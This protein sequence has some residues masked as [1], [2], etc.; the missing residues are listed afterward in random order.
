[1]F[2]E[3]CGTKIEDGAEFCQN[4]GNR[5][6]TSSNV[7]TSIN[8]PE[9]IENENI[10]Y[11]ED[12][13]RKKV[14]AVASLPYFDIMIDKKYLYVIEM[15]KYNNSTWGFILGLIILNII[16][17]FIGSA[18]GGSSDAKKRK[19]YRA[20]WI[21][22]EH[23][24]ISHDYIHN[25]FLKIPL[26][27]LRKSMIINKNKLILTY[28]DKEIVLGRIRPSFTLNKKTVEFER[29]NNYINSYVL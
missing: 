4:C 15:P 2:C 26:G 17:A 19:K 11:S 5:V 28:N 27:D 9:K 16:G 8:T 21:N 22:S 7:S 24:L 3:N 23:N 29:F 14:F 12:W 13:R 20:S 18:I 25:I 10:F 1:M 6:G